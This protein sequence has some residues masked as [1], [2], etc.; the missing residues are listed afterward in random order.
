MISSTLSPDSI[1]SSNK[2]LLVQKSLYKDVLSGCHLCHHKKNI[3]L[4]QMYFCVNLHKQNS[5]IVRNCCIPISCILLKKMLL[6]LCVYA[7]IW[8]RAD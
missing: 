4:S 5:E 1:L 6:Q 2:A 3:L 8:L 7:Y